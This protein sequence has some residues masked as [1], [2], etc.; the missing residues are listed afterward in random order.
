MTI[1]RITYSFMAAEKLSYGGAFAMAA[2]VRVKPAQ[3][4]VAQSG[5]QHRHHDKGEKEELVADRVRYEP[6]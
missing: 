1:V 4:C 6:F 3:S 5:D 2:E